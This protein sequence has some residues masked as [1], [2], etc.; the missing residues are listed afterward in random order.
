M[1]LGDAKS[2]CTGFEDRHS[3]RKKLKL[4]KHANEET[5][6]ALQSHLFRGD[7]KLEAAAVSDRDHI[8]PGAFGDH[9][10]KIQLALIRLDGATVTPDGAYGPPTAAAAL[11]YKQRRNIIN[12]SYQTKADNIV[13]R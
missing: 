6:M 9:V 2:R 7:L 10:R 13:G 3:E 5:P 1:K 11:A 12:Y 8:V 4:I